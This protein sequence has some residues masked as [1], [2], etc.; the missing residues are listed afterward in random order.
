MNTPS[1]DPSALAIVGVGYFVAVVAIYVWAALALSRVFRKSGVEGWKAWVPVLNIIELLKL[2]GFSPWLVVLGFVPV[3]NIVL[4]VVLI[5]AYH[6]INVS[7]GHGVGMTVLAALVFPVWA[8]ILGFGSSRWVGREQAGT[9]GPL[10][11]GSPF[12]AGGPSPAFGAVPPPGAPPAPFGAQPPAFGGARP[13][14]TFGGPP[15]AYPGAPAHPGAAPVSPAAA[16]ASGAPTFP[17]AA[18]PAAETPLPPVPGWTP[19]PSPAPAGD[20]AAPPAPIG[21]APLTPGAVPPAPAQ[22]PLADLFGSTP[23]APSFAA[24]APFGA[25]PAPPAPAFGAPPAPAPAAPRDDAPATT[26]VPTFDPAD[27]VPAPARTRRSAVPAEDADLWADDVAAAAPWAPSDSGEVPDAVTDAVPGAPGPVAAVRS[28]VEPA[29]D[30]APEQPAVTRVPPRSDAAGREPWAPSLSPTPDAEAFPEA[31]GPVSAIAGAPDAG[32]PRSARASVSAQHTRPHVPDE[33]DIFDET[34][35]TRRKRTPWTLVPASGRP[36]PVTGEVVILGRRP[37]TDSAFP[38]AQLVAID[39]DTRTVSKTHARL[40]LRE[41]TWTI[42]DLGSTNGV[43]LTDAAGAENEVAPH[44]EVVVGERFLL[45]DA[46]IRL[47][48][49]DA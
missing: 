27:E 24:P 8:S 43:L 29:A 11:S 19:R 5:M 48:R 38:G 35:V 34:V 2:G 42:I 23:P 7:F 44:I 28:R 9:A 36:V 15:A 13:A 39:D 14:P 40:H 31:S 22:D 46:E 49:S 45:G 30:P 25:P 10:R 26:P 47:E 41:D 37:V 1:V 32:A 3:A 21:S 18:A 12:G 6:R 16:P 20:V 33:D 4:F 17:G